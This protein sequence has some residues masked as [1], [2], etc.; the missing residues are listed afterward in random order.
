MLL[1]SAC[2]YGP[3][4]VMFFNPSIFSRQPLSC[5]ITSPVLPVALS[6]AMA[7]SLSLACER[8]QFGLSGQ[9]ESFPSVTPRLSGLLDEQAQVMKARPNIASTGRRIL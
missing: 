7:C 9:G 2:R 5:F 8:T 1:N 6:G 3:S 4:I